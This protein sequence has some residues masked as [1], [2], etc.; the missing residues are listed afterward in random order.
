MWRSRSPPQVEGF[1][2]GH[3]L[4]KKTRAAILG[5]LKEALLEALWEQPQ[6]MAAAGF[7]AT[8]YISS[9]ATTSSGFKL[10]GN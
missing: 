5:R 4:K 9:G 3:A 8:K 1:T 6:V 10:S 2:T 7:M